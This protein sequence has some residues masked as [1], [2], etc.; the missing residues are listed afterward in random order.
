MQEHTGEYFNTTLYSA[1][2]NIML[3]YISL[4]QVIGYLETQSQ[5]YLL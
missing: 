3:L 1:A 2:F 4:I 5:M